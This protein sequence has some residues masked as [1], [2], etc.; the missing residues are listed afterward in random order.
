[1]SFKPTLMKVLQAIDAGGFDER[2]FNRLRR[3]TGAQ[4]RS[5]ARRQ[6]RCVMLRSEVG[7]IMKKLD[8][9]D[10]YLLGKFIACHEQIAF[11]GAVKV[12]FG[13]LVGLGLRLDDG[14]EKEH[15]PATSGSKQCGEDRK[16]ES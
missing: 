2:A 15:P 1:M 7:S 4:A 3:F 14:G 6:R 13:A 8:E 16:A 5:Q 11:Q 9:R 10:R 12:M